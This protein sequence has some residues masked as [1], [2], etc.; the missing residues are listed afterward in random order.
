MEVGSLRE[1]IIVAFL[2]YKFGDENVETYIPITEPE[3]DVKIFQTPISI[4]TKTGQSY[5][6]VKMIWTVDSIKARQF[7]N[8]YHPSCDMIFI[9]INWNKDGRFYSIPLEVQNVVFNSL[10]KDNYINLPKE[11]TNPRGVEYSS[12]AM[13]KMVTHKD[14]FSILIRWDRPNVDYKPYNRWVEYWEKD[15]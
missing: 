10:G 4:K 13:E 6:G 1:R 12:N 5:A 3:I 9:Q 2:L 15:T 11:G 8:N 14:S 7:L